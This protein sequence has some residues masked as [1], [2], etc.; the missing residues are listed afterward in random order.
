MVL[1]G[2]VGWVVEGRGGAPDVAEGGGEVCDEGAVEEGRAAVGG[3]HVGCGEMERMRM[4]MTM[5]IM[6]DSLWDAV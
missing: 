3:G 6:F 1:R 5:R 4:I 2:L